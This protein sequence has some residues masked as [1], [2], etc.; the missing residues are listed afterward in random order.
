M[1]VRRE[2]V[3]GVAD[4]AKDLAGMN[5]VAGVDAK[6]AGLHVGV[7]GK[8]ATAEVGIVETEDDGVAVS[9]IERD[10]LGIFAR[11]LLRKAVD[12]RNDGGVGDGEDGF[13]EDRVAL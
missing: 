7:H 2:G 9:L 1:E 12:D 4:E 3:A 10:A 11:N 13:A 8:D 6:A 5:L